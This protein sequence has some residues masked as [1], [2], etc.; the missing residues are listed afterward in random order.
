[1]IKELT[2]D[3][4]GPIITGCG[5]CYREACAV[6]ISTCRRAEGS[7]RKRFVKM[8]RVDMW[9]ANQESLIPRMGGFVRIN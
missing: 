1:M 2:P 8:T 5:W 4:K 3:D 6:G 9:R 7:T